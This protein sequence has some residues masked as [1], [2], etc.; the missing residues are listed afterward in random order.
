MKKFMI[1][2]LMFLV[3]FNLFGQSYRKES[4]DVVVNFSTLEEEVSET[5]KLVKVNVQNLLDTKTFPLQYREVR[6]FFGIELEDIP[7]VIEAYYKHMESYI[8]SISRSNPNIKRQSTED[9][10]MI[11][12]LMDDTGYFF[13]NDLFDFIVFLKKDTMYRAD[14]ELKVK[15][16]YTINVL[17]KKTYSMYMKAGSHPTINDW[18]ND[19]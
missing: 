18:L 1:M 15:Y 19:W 13:L 4:K 10:N 6:E 3:G 11:E 9:K 8:K 14:Y 16:F 12:I 17:N 7:V 2:F 5:M